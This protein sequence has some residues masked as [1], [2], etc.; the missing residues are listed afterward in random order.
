M[1]TAA[2]ARAPARG[3][4]PA[5]EARRCPHKPGCSQP[6]PSAKLGAMAS[7]EMG[8]EGEGRRRAAAGGWDLQRPARRSMLQGPVASRLNAPGQFDIRR[9]EGI[10]LA[11]R[12]IETIPRC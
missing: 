9:E 3:P 11:P 10:A 12:V 1:S 6:S 2:G 8:L 5:S 4:A 7:R